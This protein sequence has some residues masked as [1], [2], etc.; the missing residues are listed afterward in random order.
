LYIKKDRN[1]EL[2]VIL[3]FLIILLALKLSRFSKIVKQ[4]GRALKPIILAQI[5]KYDVKID[6]LAYKALL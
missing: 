2:R 4:V 5:L 1:T 6:M 3:F